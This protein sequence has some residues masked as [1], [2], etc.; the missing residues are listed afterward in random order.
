MTFDRISRIVN[1]HAGFAISLLPIIDDAKVIDNGARPGI[2]DGALCLAVY[3]ISGLRTS[4]SGE[5]ERRGDGSGST[6]LVACII[7]RFQPKYFSAYVTANCNRKV[8]LSLPR[9]IFPRVLIYFPFIR[10]RFSFL[11]WS[12]KE[13]EKKEKRWTR[14]SY[15]IYKKMTRELVAG[16]RTIFKDRI[17]CFAKNYYE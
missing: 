10:Y 11:R 14:L 1:E 4:T 12:K 6:T 8:E 3:R 2:A 7:H 9:V 15:V 16:V 5:G 17:R 13:K